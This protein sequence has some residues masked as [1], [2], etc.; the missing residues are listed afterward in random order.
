MADAVVESMVGGT[1]FYRRV[2]HG[3]ISRALVLNSLWQNQPVLRT[4]QNYYALTEPSFLSR[5]TSI[6]KILRFAQDDWF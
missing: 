3:E 1:K 2:I 4:G 5:A 6:A